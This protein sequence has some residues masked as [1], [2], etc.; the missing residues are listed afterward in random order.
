MRPMEQVGFRIAPWAF[1]IVLVQFFSDLPLFLP[2][3]MFGAIS[4]RSFLQRSL[5]FIADVFF[6]KPVPD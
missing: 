4:A 1:L 6:P 3:P 5:L 2:D